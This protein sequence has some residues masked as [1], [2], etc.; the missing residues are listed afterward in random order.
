MIQTHEYFG[1]VA[2]ILCVYQLGQQKT[3]EL[4]TLLENASRGE[5]WPEL[6]DIM[7]RDHAHRVFIL[8]SEDILGEYQNTNCSVCGH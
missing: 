4:W 1:L 2:G 6:R 3:L 7:L 8:I 5:N